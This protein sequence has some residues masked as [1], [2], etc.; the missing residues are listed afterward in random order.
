MRSHVMLY[1]EIT[2]TISIHKT[3]SMQQKMLV[4]GDNEVL[5]VHFLLQMSGN[6]NRNGYNSSNFENY[7]EDVEVYDKTIGVA[8]WDMSGFIVL[9]K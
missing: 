3:M 7:V 5:K 6:Y 8:L 4:V 1:G 9:Y 2:G